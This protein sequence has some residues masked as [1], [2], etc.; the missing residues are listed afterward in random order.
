MLK[1]K[2]KSS[3]NDPQAG[4]R[5]ECA[6]PVE[7]NAKIR[8]CTDFQTAIFF[9]YPVDFRCRFWVQNTSTGSPWLISGSISEFHQLLEDLSNFEAWVK[10]T[11]CRKSF[12]EE[13]RRVNR[14]E[15]EILTQTSKFDKSAR[16]WW[17]YDMR[18]EIS[19]GGPVDVFCT[20]NRHLK[21]TR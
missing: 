4:R 9:F 6:G 17:N 7:E 8:K 20:Q 18:P 16:S 14:W 1:P 13:T 5:P 3:E 10:I 11:F 15:I 19:Q 12:F 21:S 2:L